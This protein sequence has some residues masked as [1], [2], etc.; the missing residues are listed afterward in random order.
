M[1]IVL[2][3][4]GRPDQCWL[5]LQSLA[6]IR[7]TDLAC[8]TLLHRLVPRR[9]SCRGGGTLVLATCSLVCVEVVMMLPSLL[10][11]IVLN[12]GFCSHIRLSLRHLSH[13]VSPV[14]VNRKS[15]GWRCRASYSD[16]VT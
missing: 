15:A 10:I 14:K 7:H 2:R 11:D 9:H 12:T 5:A 8:V 6:T 16:R 13:C 3:R 4:P 1:S